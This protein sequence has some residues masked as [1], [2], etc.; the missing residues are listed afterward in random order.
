MLMWSV[1]WA[2]RSVQPDLAIYRP[3]FSTF[4]LNFC[5][6]QIIR[7]ESERR[8]KRSS[9]QT[10]LLRLR[11]RY[12][13]HHSTS[14]SPTS[15]SRSCL[16]NQPSTLA[17]PLLSNLQLRRFTLSIVAKMTK[18][19]LRIGFVPEHFAAPLH[20]LAATEWVSPS[21]T[22]QTLSHILFNSSLTT[23]CFVI[24]WQ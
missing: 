9:A 15:L 21:S 16:Y 6:R 17:L 11:L 12:T 3:L 10:L 2:F 4:F 13:T 8:L 5:N 7:S 20:H 22:P 14:P 18:K 24:L 1:L 19:C 23:L